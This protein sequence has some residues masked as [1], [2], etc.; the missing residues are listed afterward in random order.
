ME[1]VRY[2]FEEPREI[3]LFGKY[4]REVLVYID[5]VELRRNGAV[6]QTLG[7]EDAAEL[8]WQEAGRKSAILFLKP[9]TEDGIQEPCLSIRCREKGHF[10]RLKEYYDAFWKENVHDSLGHVSW[11]EDLAERLKELRKLKKQ[12]DNGEI[13]K[14]E[15]ARLRQGLLVGL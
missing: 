9:K 12:Y 4:G 11:T 7:F 1:T 14:E 13:T 15:Y 3:P 10:D 6:E 8:T 2:R 5:R